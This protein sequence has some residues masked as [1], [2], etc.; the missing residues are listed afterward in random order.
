MAFEHSLQCYSHKSFVKF[1]RKGEGGGSPL[2]LH[3]AGGLTCIV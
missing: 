3:V 2:N 1:S